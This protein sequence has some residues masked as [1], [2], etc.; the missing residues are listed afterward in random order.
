MQF[1]LTGSSTFGMEIPTEKHEFFLYR[2]TWTQFRVRLALEC[3][4]SRT[5]GFCGDWFYLGE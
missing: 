1:M 5:K 4:Q 2:A 3:S